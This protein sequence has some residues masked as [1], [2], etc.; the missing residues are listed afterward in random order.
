PTFTLDADYGI[1]ANAFALHSTVA[2]NPEKGVLPNLGYFVTAGMNIPI[3]NWGSTESKLR[4]A[5]Y[6]RQQARVELSQTQ[7]EALSNLSQYY[8]EAKVARSEL[9]TLQQD[10]NLASDSLRLTKLQYKAGDAIEL[11][12]LSAQTALSSAKNALDMGEARYRVAL[13]TLQ[14]LTGEF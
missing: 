4:Q 9:A 7:R 11:E 12:V 5:E 13:A 1:E 2:A 8:N 10:A 3:W 6:R 14:T